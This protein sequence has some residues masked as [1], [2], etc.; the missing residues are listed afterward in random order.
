[1]APVLAAWARVTVHR[2]AHVQYDR[3]LY[4]VPFRLVGERLWLKAA[5]TTVRIYRDHEL[6]AVHARLYRLGHRA[7]VDDHI[8]L[9]LLAHVTES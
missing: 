9:P 8:V 2:D 7:T 1:M 4:S 6:V 5:A 3:W